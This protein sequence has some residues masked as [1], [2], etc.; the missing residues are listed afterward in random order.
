VA[1]FAIRAPSLDELLDPYSVEPLDRRP[2][3]EDVRER[4]L[5]AWIDARRERPS[6]LSVELPATEKR[7]R[8]GPSL[9]TAIRNDFVATYEASKGFHVFTRGERREAEIAFLFLIVCLLASSLVDR[10]TANEAL[11]IGISQ[12]LVVLGWV[13]MWQPAQQVFEAVSR[14]L[15]HGRYRELSEVPIEIVWA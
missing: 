5:R 2:L 9:Q 13:A 12:G 4:I 1:P 11:F 8:L 3:R 14:R 7:E 6:H 10:A 15:N